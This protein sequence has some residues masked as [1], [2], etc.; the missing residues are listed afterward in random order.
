LN[1]SNLQL[2]KLRSQFCVPLLV[3][4]QF[5]KIRRTY[6][7]RREEN[8]PKAQRYAFLCD[9]LL[10]K[11]TILKVLCVYFA[12]KP[13]STFHFRSFSSAATLFSRRNCRGAWLN[14]AN[15]NV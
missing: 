11:L 8:Q 2:K 9:V 4:L 1:I 3:P 5:Q 13:A 14:P 12:Q 10:F 6:K 15:G 7:W